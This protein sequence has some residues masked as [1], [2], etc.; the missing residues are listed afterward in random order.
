MALATY[1]YK[2]S[3]NAVAKLPSLLAVGA[4]PTLALPALDSPFLAVTVDSSHKPDLD[5]AMEDLGFA[6]VAEGVG[7][8]KL[9][10]AIDSPYTPGEELLI[11]ADASLGPVLVIP[12]PLA[13]FVTTVRQ[14]KVVKTDGT[15]NPVTFDPTGGELVNGTPSY[16]LSA[17]YA[18]LEVFSGPSEWHLLLQPSAPAPVSGLPVTTTDAL[19][20]GNIVAFDS[21]NPSR[22]VLA[23]PSLLLVPSRYDAKGIAITPAPAGTPTVIHAIPGQRV[24]VRFTGVPPALA[25]GSRVYLSTI[26]GQ[27][28]LIPPGSGNAIVQVGI[29]VGANGITLTP[30]VV[31][32]FG[33]IALIS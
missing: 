32:Q 19:L 33:I 31:F 21:L 7:K 8:E 26:P 2:T 1:Y 23:D 5:A 29:L 9:I 12:P 3:G 15:A 24:P 11:L 6:F 27:A 17:Q 22:T 28:T 13:T 25:N 16:S 4:S 18:A 20:P 14:L 10:T 30:D